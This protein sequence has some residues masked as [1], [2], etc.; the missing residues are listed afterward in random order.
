MVPA[1]SGSSVSITLTLARETWLVVGLRQ[2][3]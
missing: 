3:R 2:I 1:A